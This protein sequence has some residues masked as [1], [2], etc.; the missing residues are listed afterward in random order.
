[1]NSLEKNFS[2]KCILG[3][4]VHACNNVGKVSSAINWVILSVLLTFTQSQT[5]R[6]YKKNLA[7]R[8]EKE[9]LY[10]CDVYF[11]VNWYQSH[12]STKM[13]FVAVS[14]P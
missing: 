8:G 14:V 12:L 1:M 4:T 7:D 2:V 3:H 6:N 10:I 5:V 13:V 11:I 9:A